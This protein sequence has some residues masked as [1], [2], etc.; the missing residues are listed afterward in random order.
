MEHKI[1]KS[2]TKAGLTQAFLLE[3][4]ENPESTNCKDEKSSLPTYGI[5][6]GLLH[7][8]DSHSAKLKINSKILL[9][10]LMDKLYPNCTINRADRL[11]RRIKGFQE[12]DKIEDILEVTWRPQPS[13][14]INYSKNNIVHITLLSLVNLCKIKLHFLM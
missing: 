1:S 7:F 4:L 3:L 6:I 9:K 10:Q 12:M 5:L 13:G 2:L 8:A 14:T 11:Y